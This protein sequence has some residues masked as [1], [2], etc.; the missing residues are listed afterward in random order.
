MTYNVF[1]GTLNLTQRQLR[2]RCFVVA[3]GGAGTQGR[4]LSVNNAY[5]KSYRSYVEI[6]WNVGS[7]EEYRRGYEGFVDVKCVTAADGEM[8]YREH[9]PKLGIH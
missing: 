5:D 1:G 9:L 8:Y 2:R 7:T 3:E 6:I 4:V